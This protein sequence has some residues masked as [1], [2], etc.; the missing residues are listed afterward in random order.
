MSCPRGCC[1]TYRE[2]LD[3]VRLGVTSIRAVK[4]RQESRDM[5]AY[6]RLRRNGVQPKSI[7]GSSEIER[8]ASTTHEVENRNII[9]DP[10]LRK[11]VTSAFESAK[12]FAT[13]PIGPPDAA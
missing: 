4:E 13:K 1:A 6:A 3:G 5:D 8:F 7:E 2:H 9:T 12:D 11:R 10:K